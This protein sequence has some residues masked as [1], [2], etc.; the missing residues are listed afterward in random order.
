MDR[1]GRLIGLLWLI[2]SSV[3]MAQSQDETAVRIFQM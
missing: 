1:L 2:G 3:L